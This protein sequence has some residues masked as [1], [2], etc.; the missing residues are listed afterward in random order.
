MIAET[1]VKTKKPKEL[2]MTRQRRQLALSFIWEYRR[3]HQ[4]SPT[5]EEIALGVGYSITAAGTAFGL[6]EALIDE[7]WLRRVAPGARMILPAKDELDVYTEITDPELK[8]IA[9][10]QRNLRI[11]RRL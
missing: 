8:R 10:Q 3:I 1:A 4:V 5:Y 7:G 9:K 6:V 2:I 11:L